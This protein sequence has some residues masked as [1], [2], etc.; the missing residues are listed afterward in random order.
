MT[1]Q[2]A[3]TARALAESLDTAARTR[4]TVAPLSADTE[5]DPVTAY[6][7]QEQVVALR[8]A[9]GERVIGGK[10]GLT[11]KAKQVAMG[12]H[13]P[14]H[15]IVTSGLAITGGALPLGELIHPRVEPEVAFIL[16]EPV[17]GPDATASDVLAATSYVCVALDVIDSRYEGFAFKYVDAIAD[18]ASSAAFALGDDLVAPTMDLAL[19]GCTLEVDGEVADTASGAAV[20]GHPAAAVAFMANSLAETGKRLEAGWVVLSGGLTAPVPMKAGRTVTATIAGIGSVSLT[21]R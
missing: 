9:R 12:V 10:L 15:G 20:M 6:Q 1:T 2:S 4:T 18:N 7:V 21:A 14:L 3:P 11:S 19:A 17:S 5:L 13:Q 8:V 16:K